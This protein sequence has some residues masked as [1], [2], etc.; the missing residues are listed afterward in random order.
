MFNAL[1]FATI[2]D[3]V[4]DVST[5]RHDINK[6]TFKQWQKY[7]EVLARPLPSIKSFIDREEIL[8][9]KFPLGE[10]ILFFYLYESTDFHQGGRLVVKTMSALL[11]P[12]QIPSLF[13]KDDFSTQ[14]ST[15]TVRAN[16]APGALRPKL[17]HHQRLSLLTTLERHFPHD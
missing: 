4:R 14:V 2:S 5:R 11:L 15:I 13:E 6:P 8:R 3:C 10:H 9:L 12:S 7:L 17:T 16:I 1:T